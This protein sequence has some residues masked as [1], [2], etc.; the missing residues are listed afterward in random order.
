MSDN[1]SAYSESSGGQDIP[2]GMGGM[3]SQHYLEGGYA[4]AETQRS[5]Q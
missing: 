2:M 5:Q 4:E 3:L 1:Y